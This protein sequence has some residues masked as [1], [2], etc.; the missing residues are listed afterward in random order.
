[1]ISQIKNWPSFLLNYIGLKNVGEIY[2]FR[3]GIKIKTAEGVDAVTIAVIFMKKEYGEVEGASVIIDIGAN[4]GTYSIFAASSSNNVKIYSY[5]PV[6]KSFGLLLENIKL[7]NLE[8]RVFPFN[9]AVGGKRG[10][11]QIYFGDTSPFNSMYSQCST[12]QITVKCVTLKDVFQTNKIAHCD[13]LKLDCEGAEFEILF[14]TADDVFERIKEIRM[15]Y[16]NIGSEY[17]I[18]DLIEFLMKKGFEV[19]RF[20]EDRYRLLWLKKKS[21]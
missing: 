4:I 3:K 13:L 9:Y 21:V 17:K 14:N 11:R 7:N 8:N 16:H 1:M 15:E 6:P 2:V 12:K 18:R 19:V 10:E 5:E 20:E